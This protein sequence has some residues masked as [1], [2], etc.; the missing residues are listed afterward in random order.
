MNIDASGDGLERWLAAFR[1]VT[2]NVEAR[3]TL[4]IRTI[5]VHLPRVAEA[6][7]FGGVISLRWD[8]PGKP[9]SFTDNWAA[10]EQFTRDPAQQLLVTLLSRASSVED[11]KA[12]RAYS[13]R[14]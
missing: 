12:V 11:V 5:Q 14:S 6:L 8:I 3:E 1:S 10:L 13:Y 2:G 4:L 7:A 9:Y